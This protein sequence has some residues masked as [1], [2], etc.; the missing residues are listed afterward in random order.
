MR[1]NDARDRER[2]TLEQKWKTSHN[3]AKLLMNVNRVDEWMPNE[4]VP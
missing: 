4:C 2:Y 3:Y 1:P